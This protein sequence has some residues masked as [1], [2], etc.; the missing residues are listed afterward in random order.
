MDLYKY[1]LAGVKIIMPS[2]ERNN[3]RAENYILEQI[4]SSPKEIKEEDKPLFRDHRKYI[5]IGW[6]DSYEKEREL[7]RDFFNSLRELELRTTLSVKCGYNLHDYTSRNIIVIM[8]EKEKK[9]VRAERS[10]M[11]KIIS[12][13]SEIRFFPELD[14]KRQGNYVFLGWGDSNEEE[15]EEW[16]KFHS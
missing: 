9:K 12:H 5:F 2:K 16:R 11:E 14:L 6:T 1:A 8:P 13:P 7:W 10:V 15:R 3:L 4:V